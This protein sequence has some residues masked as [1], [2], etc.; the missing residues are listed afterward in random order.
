MFFQYVGITKLWNLKGQGNVAKA[1]RTRISYNSFYMLYSNILVFK[2]LKT[3]EFRQ[4]DDGWKQLIYFQ[5]VNSL[6]GNIYTNE[7]HYMYLKSLSLRKSIQT[8]PLV[9]LFAYPTV[10]LWRGWSASSQSLAA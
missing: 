3:N 4:V 2:W 7:R 9:F 1:F 5:W 10:Y 6:F 8:L